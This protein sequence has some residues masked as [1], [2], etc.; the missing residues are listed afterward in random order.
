MP[1]SGWKS[2]RWVEDRGGR[3]APAWVYPP[4]GCRSGWFAAGDRLQIGQYTDFSEQLQE[5]R[6]L[7][8]PIY[9]L[10]AQRA[11]G[12]AVSIGFDRHIQTAEASSLKLEKYEGGVEAAYGLLLPTSGTM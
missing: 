11:L 5:G 9:A 12:L 6:R 1:A 3:G 8:L 4:P 10:A 2:H 7:Q